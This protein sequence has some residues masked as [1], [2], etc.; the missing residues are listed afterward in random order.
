MFDII[1]F[2]ETIG[3]ITSVLSIIVLMPQTFKSIFE[4]N[5]DGLSLYTLILQWIS[6]C[7]W[8]LYAFVLDELSMIISMGFYFLFSSI[9]FGLKIIHSCR[10]IT[11][12]CESKKGRRNSQETNIELENGQETNI[13]LENGQETNIE[14]ENGQETNI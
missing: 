7:F 14:L 9:L 3:W 13:E 10:V 8:F 11:R 2:K 4:N 5:T 1:I 6:S 12:F